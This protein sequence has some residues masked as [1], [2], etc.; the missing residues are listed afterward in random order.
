VG[1]TVEFHSN[2]STASGY[3]AT[4]PG[5]AGPGVMVIQE[6]WG[7]VPQIKRVCD[8]LAAEGFVALAPD[9][10]HGES[11]SHTEMDKAGQLMSSLPA[12][13]A[14]R[15][16]A[17]AIDFLLSNDAV[18]GDSVGV[19]GFCMGGALSLMIAAQ[20]GS[21]IGAAVA[22]YGTPPPDRAPD[23][24]GLAAP[25]LIHVAEADSFFPVEAFHELEASLKKIGKDVT[26]YVYPGTGHAFANEDNALGTYD[27]EAARLA[28]E[29][30]VEFL[31]KHLG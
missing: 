15:D 12:D 22:Y 24:S 13:R 3:L 10:Y 18:R 14:V 29:R 16:M 30:T 25:V 26:S 7:L 11:A 1:D 21:R 8:K 19:V 28:W 17:G 31:R 23:W 4:P 9:L 20:Q 5:G 27:P 2:G 6:W